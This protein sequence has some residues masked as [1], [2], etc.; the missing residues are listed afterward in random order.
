MALYVNKTDWAKCNPVP[1]Q[2]N[3]D[4]A[5]EVLNY[6]FNTNTWKERPDA[7][8]L[9]VRNWR[10]KLWAA[11]TPTPPL[12]LVKD[13]D[14]HWTEV[15]VQMRREGASW[16]QIKA[17]VNQPISTIRDTVKRAAA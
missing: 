14:A 7:L 16:N 5:T 4:V 12:A 15:A 6:L 11:P 10:Q 13:E 8:I 17:A 1:V 3:E 9:K 2:V